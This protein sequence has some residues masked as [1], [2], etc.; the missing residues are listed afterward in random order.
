MRQ[1]VAHE[2]Q[3]SRRTQTNR[4]PL[5]SYA[6]RLVEC[7]ELVLLGHD[8]LGPEAEGRG[9]DCGREDGRPRSVK[10][11]PVHRRALVVLDCPWLQYVMCKA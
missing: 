8:A 11:G 6:G 9:H 3:K 4:D 7:R 5:L 1:C 2:N 10:V